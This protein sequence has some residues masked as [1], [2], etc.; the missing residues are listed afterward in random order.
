[1]GIHLIQKGESALKPVVRIILDQ[2]YKRAFDYKTSI[3]LCGASKNSPDSVRAQVDRMLRAW[4]FSYRYD[5]VY[6][7]DL[8]D[9]LL[10]GQNHQDLLTLENILADSVDAIVLIIES[11]GAVA[12]LG[13]FAG[14]ESLRKKSVCVVD[15]KYKLSKS[16]INY[17]PVRLLKDKGEG[18]TLFVDYSKIGDTDE[19][20]RRLPPGFS[21]A[22][23]FVGSPSANVPRINI[24]LN[25]RSHVRHARY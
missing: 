22:K 18:V 1:M 6:S 25:A 14:S 16:F 2:V 12:E 15:R 21:L 17:G 19:S 9:E 11:Y 3:F 5:L 24:G 4:R 7:E 13:A 20:I 23:R 10:F 8:F